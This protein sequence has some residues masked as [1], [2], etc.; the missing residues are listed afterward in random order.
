MIWKPQQITFFFAGII[1]ITF[2]IVVVA[3]RES[4][5]NGEFWALRSLSIPENTKF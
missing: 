4:S 5:E 1:I 3:L 2:S